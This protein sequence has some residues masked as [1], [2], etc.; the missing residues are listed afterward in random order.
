MDEVEKY[1]DLIIE[2]MEKLS[3]EENEKIA[4]FLNKNIKKLK[5]NQKTQKIINSINYKGYVMK[6][7][8]YHGCSSDLYDGTTIDYYSF[9][10]CDINITV[11][12]P[13]IDKEDD[14][15]CSLTIYGY[16]ID[17]YFNNSSY[18]YSYKRESKNKY[19]K[20]DK[21]DKKF[22]KKLFKIA[23]KYNITICKFFTIILDIIDHVVDFT[24]GE[25]HYVKDNTFIGAGVSE[26]LGDI[27]KNYTDKKKLFFDN[28]DDGMLYEMIFE[29][30]SESDNENECENKSKT[31]NKSDNESDN[32]SEC[33][34]D[35]ES[36]NESECE[37]ESDNESDK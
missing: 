31:K 30:V 37:S 29:F 19:D 10:L 18:S 7:F 3:L 20:N 5:N 1:W 11:Q 36:D 6:T 25:Y 22:V 28:N 15:G 24:L 17:G 27:Y 35:N 8:N 9:D 4:S 16:Y 2:N 12:V 32:E 13:N 33:E 34:S 23:I 21:H 14:R 26:I